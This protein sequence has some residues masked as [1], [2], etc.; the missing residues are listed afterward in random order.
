[1]PPADPIDGEVIL[2]A[3]ALASVGTRLPTLV[4]QAQADLGPRVEE[5]RR[6]YEVVHEGDGRVAF[7]V[8]EGFWQEAGKR[9]DFTPKEI[10]AIRRAHTRQL[11][12]L[13]RPEGRAEEFET[14]LEIREA[15]VIGV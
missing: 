7:F 14:G 3:S 11:L 4:E 15:A 2:L 13:G 10:D 1:M 8:E 6:H 5:F 9:L 12:H